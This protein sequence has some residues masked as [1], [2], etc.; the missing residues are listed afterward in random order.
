MTRN[1]AVQFLLD[2]PYKFGHLIGFT[3]LTELHNDWIKDMVRGKEDKTLQAHRGSYKTTCVSI[4]LAIIIVLLPNKTTLFMRKTDT[5]TKE[6]V[7][8][9]KKILESQQM[10]VFVNAIYGKSVQLDRKSVV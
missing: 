1:D 4:A 7:R 8:Q 5:D 9:V 10:Q 6:I 2:K 3:K